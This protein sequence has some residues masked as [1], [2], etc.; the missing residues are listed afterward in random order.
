MIFI[1]LALFG[2]GPSQIFFVRH[3]EKVQDQGSNPHLTERGQDRVRKLVL[4]L[5]SVSFDGVYS[6][7]Y[8]RTQ[9]TA[10][11]IAKQQ[12]TELTTVEVNNFAK[13]LEELATKSGNFLIAGHSNTIPEW[14]AAL[15]CQSQP[16]DES[17]YSSLFLV[18]KDEDSCQVLRFNFDTCME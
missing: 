8:L 11:P 9:E 18:T 5:E 14:I 16:I 17:D 2:E 6:T 4:F 3:A 7:P 12:Q 13:L 15:G 1:L 10:G